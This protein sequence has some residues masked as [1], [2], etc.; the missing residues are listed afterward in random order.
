MN[1]NTQIV[2]QGMDGAKKQINEAYKEGKVEEEK[3]VE[4]KP[5][6][7]QKLREEFGEKGVKIYRLIDGQKN[8][9]QIMKEVGVDEDTIIEIFKFMEKEDMIKLKH[10]VS[11]ST[12]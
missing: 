11:S 3:S 7:E 2:K 9:E 5:F 12:K 1:K 8:A 10:P 6:Y 4:S